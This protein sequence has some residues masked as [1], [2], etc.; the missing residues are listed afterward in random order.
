MEKYIDRHEAGKVLAKA[1]L[2]YQNRQDVIVLAL[3]R[4][5]V[6]VAHEIAKT[7]HVP[8]DIFVVRKLGVP[9]HEEL[10]FGAV[11]SGGTVTYNDDVLQYHH[12]S[13]PIIKQVIHAETQELT[14]RESVY[15]GNK[16]YPDLKNKVIILV[17]DGIA[18]G[19]TMRTAIK[20]LR[21]KHPLLIIV[22][23]PVAEKSTCEEIAHI[24]DK[25]ICPLQPTLFYAVGAWYDSFPQTTDAEV[26]NLL[27]SL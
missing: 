21:A 18:T 24:A 2:S 14:R 16:P 13:E 15:R 20:A 19:A 5:G 8:L 10:A 9:G 6:P 7:L 12:I 27:K 3:P 23:V 1:L 25:I 26:L 11:A 22:A 17:D 4:G